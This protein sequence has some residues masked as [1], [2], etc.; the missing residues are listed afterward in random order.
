MLAPLCL[1]GY[2]SIPVLSLNTS[3]LP[4][5]SRTHRTTLSYVALSDS[6]GNTPQIS[7]STFVS[8]RTCRQPAGSS[9]HLDVAIAVDRRHVSIYDVFTALGWAASRPNVRGEV[10]QMFNARSSHKQA[11]RLAW[12]RNV[13]MSVARQLGTAV[14]GDQW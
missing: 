1:W 13:Q 9:E 3:V 8:Q 14:V 11:A 4:H 6:S 7:T 2:I 5:H 10:L 12:L